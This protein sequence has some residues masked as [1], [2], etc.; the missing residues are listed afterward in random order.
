MA[1]TSKQILTWRKSIGMPAQFR[2]RLVYADWQHLTNGVG[3]DDY[4]YSGNSLHDPDRTGAGTQPPFYNELSAMYWSYRV[5]GSKIEVAYDNN[6]T[7]GPLEI[8]VLPDIKV[9]S[10]AAAIE[11]S[12]GNRYA[13]GGVVATE[14]NT[15]TGLSNY[16]KYKVIRGLVNV[17]DHEDASASIGSNP[18][19]E[20]FWHVLATSVDGNANDCWI[21]VKITYYAEFFNPRAMDMS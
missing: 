2:T 19:D 3:L 15:M 16:M 14:A 7:G 4:V 10:Q 12:K 6:Q 17:E 13:V 8:C 21:S 5:Y 9:D 18:N 20:F 11:A 1:T